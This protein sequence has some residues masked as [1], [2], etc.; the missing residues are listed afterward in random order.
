MVRDVR[1]L[2]AVIEQETFEI[3]M[4]HAFCVHVMLYEGS[5][6]PSFFLC[7]HAELML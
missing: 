1:Y 7:A 2:S 3:Q 4:L 6:L 5:Y